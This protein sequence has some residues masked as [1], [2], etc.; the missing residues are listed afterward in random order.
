MTVPLFSVVFWRHA[1]PMRLSL[2]LKRSVTF[3]KIGALHH[4]DSQTG[5][6]LARVFPRFFSRFPNI[7]HAGFDR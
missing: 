5:R 7:A 3:S 6:E 2:L 4:L 1:G